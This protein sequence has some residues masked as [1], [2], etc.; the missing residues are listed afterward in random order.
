MGDF[1]TLP[2]SLDQGPMRHLKAHPLATVGFPD[3]GRGVA[4]DEVLNG[5]LHPSQ[6]E[7]ILHPVA[8]G[9]DHMFGIGGDRAEVFH[10]SRRGPVSAPWSG[11]AEEQ[12]AT[13]GAT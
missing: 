10:E 2:Q 9:V 7:S 4:E 5:L 3:G 11:I 8:E 6:A 13:R 12:R 1:A